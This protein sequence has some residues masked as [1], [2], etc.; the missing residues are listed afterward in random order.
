VQDRIEGGH[1]GG[2]LILPD[3]ATPD[4]IF[5]ELL[6]RYAPPWLTGLILAGATAAAMSTLDSILHS[7][8]TVLTRDVYQRY[9]APDRSQSHYLAFGRLVV[10]ALLAVGWV[11]TVY[12]TDYLVVLVMLSGVGALQL[13]PAVLG[14]CY[15]TRRLT[16]SAGVLAGI[17]AGLFT[18]YLTRVAY[19]QPLGMHEAVW[20]LGVN[21]VVTIFVSRR[22]RQPSEATVERI[23]GEVERFVYG[24]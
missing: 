7:N 24:D 22:T 11:L 16:T 23:H 2:A 3:L 20:S 10:V 13:M 6:F 21:F 17:C 1:R 15:P 9:I 12:R 8:M 18:L 5:P 14:V 19:Y 4:Q